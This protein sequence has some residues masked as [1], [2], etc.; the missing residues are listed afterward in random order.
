MALVII[1]TINSY[2][3]HYPLSTSCHSVLIS[4]PFYIINL[5]NLM[6]QIFFFFENLLCTWSS[7]NFIAKGAW[8][9]VPIGTLY[10]RNP[11]RRTIMVAYM[12]AYLPT[13]LPA[14]SPLASPWWVIVQWHQQACVFLRQDYGDQVISPSASQSTASCFPTQSHPFRAFLPYPIFPIMACC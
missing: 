12:V 4:S 1:I 6:K 3:M 5:H 10:N 7:W 9:M 8:I 13:C 11:S 2:C 14:Y